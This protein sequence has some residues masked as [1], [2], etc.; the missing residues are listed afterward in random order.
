MELEF[1]KILEQLVID[2]LEPLKEQY[3]NYNFNF[4]LLSFPQDDDSY[5][6][7]IKGFHKNEYDDTKTTPF[8]LLRLF[9]LYE[10]NQIHITNIFI[11]SFMKHNGI[12]KK[13]IQKIFILASV[14]KYSLFLVDMVPSFYDKMIAR[15]ASP[16]IDCDDAVEI[17]PNTLL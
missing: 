1:C 4:E 7:E 14:V 6:I 16:C 12:G 9:V 15:G 8:V 2:Y 10:C 13:L 3:S 17:T 5:M 11:P